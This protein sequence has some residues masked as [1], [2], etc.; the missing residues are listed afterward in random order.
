MVQQ[1]LYKLFLS[2]LIWQSACT[3]NP[4][5]IL[6]FFHHAECK[7]WRL[8]TVNQNTKELWWVESQSA[9]P[10]YNC[11]CVY[12]I[13]CH[14]IV[15]SSLFVMKVSSASGKV[16]HHIMLDWGPILFWRSFSS[17]KLDWPIIIT[18]NSVYHA[19]CMCNLIIPTASTLVVQF[20]IHF[21]LFLDWLHNYY[22]CQ[23]LIWRARKPR[24]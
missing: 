9:L 15:F 6:R 11:H 7:A 2:W 12:F 18:Q 21:T 17:R 22:D 14:R 4:K 13:L 20:L 23:K 1:C 19:C 3:Q 5:N 16:S 8:L 10:V 24:N